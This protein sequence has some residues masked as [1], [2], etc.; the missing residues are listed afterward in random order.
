MTLPAT[1]RPF[2]YETVLRL[3]DTDSAGVMFFGH[4]FRHLHDAYESFM[5]SLGFALHLMI[6]PPDPAS[7]LALPIVHAEADYLSP[8]RHGDRMLIEIT[9]AEVRIRSFSLDYRV[10]GAEGR[11][12][13][14]ART[15]HVRASHPT[16]DTAP[17]PDD[18]RLALLACAPTRATHAKT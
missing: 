10:A 9:V 6:A 1:P 16:S 3:H 4:L 14:R 5:A 12:C 13:A 8:L 7:T 17:L 2:V 18:L 15:V 11:T